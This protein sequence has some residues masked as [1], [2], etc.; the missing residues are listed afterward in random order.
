MP[1][2]AYAGP[3]RETHQVTVD[4]GGVPSGSLLHVDAC[5]SRRTATSRIFRDAGYDVIEAPSAAAALSAAT[6]QPLAAAVVHVDLPDAPGID[7][8]ETL[9][10]LRAD[11]PVLLVSS[12]SPSGHEET[13]WL[14]SADGCILEQSDDETVVKL[15][16]AAVSCIADWGPSDRWIVS[17]LRGGILDASPAAATLLNGAVRGLLGRSLLM[18]FDHDREGW[19]RAMVRAS[20]GERVALEGTLR[21]RERRPV[22]V[23]V[24]ISR[25]P[26]SDLPTL[27]WQITGIG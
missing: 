22:Q 19:R 27:R 12:R 21:P 8:C 17:D 26:A 6:R 13:R 5:A 4:K 24:A 14:R 7:V 9:K 25:E 1:P 11:L 2:T 18:F 10:G 3:G 16:D 23:S 15:L 20:L